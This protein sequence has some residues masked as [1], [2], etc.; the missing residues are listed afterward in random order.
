MSIVVISLDLRPIIAPPAIPERRFLTNQLPALYRLVP[1][2]VRKAKMPLAFYEAVALVV[3]ALDERPIPH[4]FIEH[5]FD[6]G[7]YCPARFTGERAPVRQN[8]C[9][10][11]FALGVRVKVLR[12]SALVFAAAV[13]FTACGGGSSPGSAPAVPTTSK[14][15]MAKF[16]IAIPVSSASSAVKKPQYVSSNTKSATISVNGAAATLV[17][18]TATSSNCTTGA[19]GL[20]CN[21]S[22]TAPIG[23]D[24]FVISLFASTDG[25]GSP[26][27]TQ[28][29]SAS[30]T[31]NQT[32]PVD[33]TLNAVAASLSLALSNAA[34]QERAATDLT[35]TVT[36]KDASGAT[37]IA[38]GNF[39]SAIT[40]ADD[41]T[42]GATSLSATQVAAPNANT[43]TVH[44]SGAHVVA[45]FTATSGTLAPASV[46]LQSVP[47]P[48]PTP[49]PTPT[50]TPTPT[51]TPT[52]VAATAGY[53]W[54]AN[55]GGH[56]VLAFD[57][58]SIAGGSTPTSRKPSGVPAGG[59]TPA[60]VVSGSNTGFD[61]YS[62]QCVQEDRLGNLY[63]AGSQGSKS[64]GA[65]MYF[66]SGGLTTGNL[67]PA[68]TI[69]GSNTTLT[70]PVGCAFDSS[71]NLWLANDDNY[72]DSLVMFTHAQ[73]VSGGNI[74]PSVIVQPLTC[75]QNTSLC[76]TVG[77]AFDPSGDL[78]TGSLCAATVEY[79]PQQ[80][81]STGAPNPVAYI[82]PGGVADLTFDS[83]G[84][85]WRALGASIDEYNAANLQFAPDVTPDM[86]IAGSATQIATAVSLSMD[87]SGNLWVADATKSALLMYSASSLSAGA[88]NIA[89]TVIL[90]GPTTQLNAPSGV[91]FFPLPRI[92]TVRR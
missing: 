72:E 39:A 35:L 26:L 67:T 61:T 81:S 33:I 69:A 49:S 6:N 25:T 91:R 79:Q 57:P 21:I 47:A 16:T 82:Q 28:S 42:S 54:V 36:A 11:F 24:T 53:L 74:A 73:L 9:T 44:Y 3:I 78:W 80:I 56:S 59:P 30:I 83:S 10:A 86:T 89:P 15:G 88:G 41:D 27:A 64:P 65:I 37:I 8:R 92:P 1:G 70:N 84:N 29:I 60:I 75:C 77:V 23:N 58:S 18:L 76:N 43:V 62:P 87:A 7:R 5:T 14:N 63:V 4:R 38:P 32:T 40:L 13:L 71:G 85:L 20:Q 34:P 46:T 68:A 48:T 51:P 12:G 45:H 52:P 66:P 90:S 2:A 17:P 50:A 31:A 19:S 22:V 55:T